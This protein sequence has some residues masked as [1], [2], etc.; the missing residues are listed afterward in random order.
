MSRKDGA[1][2][3]DRSEDYGRLNWGPTP[4]R[5]V[6]VREG[7]VRSVGGGLLLQSR[8]QRRASKG[9]HE[10]LR[11]RAAGRDGFTGFNAMY[12]PDPETQEIQVKAERGTTVAFSGC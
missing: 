10:E 2:S 9:L 8:S 7:R 4:N 11:G 3:K 1:R 6:V 5:G 12:E